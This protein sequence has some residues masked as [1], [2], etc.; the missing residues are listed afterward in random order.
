MDARGNDTNALLCDGWIATL[1]LPAPLDAA[2][3]AVLSDAC[4]AVAEDAEIRVLVVRAATACWRGWPDDL[5]PDLAGLGLIGD[6]FGVLASVPQPTI[7]VVVGDVFD[8][9]LELA[10]CADIRVASSSARF[11]LP[12]VGEGA[13]PSAGGLQRL[14]RAI[15]RSRATQLM[16]MGPIDAGTARDWGLVSDIAA[17]PGAAAAT[18]AGRIVERG[19]LATRFAKEAVA[20][21]VEMPLDQALRYE[22]DL[23]ILL[24]SSADRA[25]GVR[26][27]VEKRLPKFEGR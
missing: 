2:A 27:F 23:T 13:F 24:Q 20:R 7:A 9:G 3:V 12:G 21:G 16:L 26:A 22:T 4:T 6:P 25:E 5:V 10:L 8:A 19:P 14:S 18:L 17:D 11:G 15:G 1:T